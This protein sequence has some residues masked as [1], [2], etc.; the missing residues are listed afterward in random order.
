MANHC[1]RFSVNMQL[2]G[3]V[4]RPVILHSLRY[5]TLQQVF[6]AGVYLKPGIRIPDSGIRI[7]ES[8]I[9]DLKS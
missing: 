9:L 6:W 4:I 5:V 3:F 2:V 8:G 7:L 1:L